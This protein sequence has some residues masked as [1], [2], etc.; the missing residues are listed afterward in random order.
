MYSYNAAEDPLFVLIHSF[1]DYIRALRSN[2]RG[3]DQFAVDEMDQCIPFAFESTSGSDVTL[4]TV[5]N[6]TTICHLPGAVCGSEQVTIRKMFDIGAWNIS[7]ELGSFWNENEELQS[8]CGDILN[9]EWFYSDA[10]MLEMMDKESVLHVA[11]WNLYLHEQ[12]TGWLMMRL[13]IM[14]VILWSVWVIM[15]YYVLQWEEGKSTTVSIISVSKSN[16][17]FSVGIQCGDYGTF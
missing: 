4:D 17:D 8:Q 3:F 12:S 10:G 5:M 2:C 16:A 15:K 7:Y 11:G 13:I 1:L 9:S 6:F 14:A